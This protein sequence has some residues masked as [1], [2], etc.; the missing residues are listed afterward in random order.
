MPSQLFV[1]FNLWTFDCIYYWSFIVVV[2][3]FWL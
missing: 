2:H 3:M 1:V